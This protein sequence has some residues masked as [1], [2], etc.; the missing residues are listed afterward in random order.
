MTDGTDGAPMNSDALTRGRPD[1]RPA[2]YGVG[3][4][5]RSAE[6]ET[7]AGRSSR[8]DARRPARPGRRP[9]PGWPSH[10]P[11]SPVRPTSPVR[12]PGPGRSG[13]PAS[14]SAAEP[15]VQRVKPPA[16]RSAPPGE[17]SA[18][19]TAQANHIRRTSFFLL[20]LGL[21]GGGLVCLLVVNTTLAA[22]SFEISR[23]QHQN[24]ARTEQVQQLQQQVAVERSAAMIEK[25]ARRLHMRPDPALLFVDLR[26]KSIQ[27]SSRATGPGSGRLQGWSSVRAGHH[28]ARKTSGKAAAA[29]R[30]GQ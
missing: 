27:G 30:P 3:I 22:N 11:K 14:T 5:A 13:R 18:R 24:T 6:N 12:P 9:R 26:T 1:T 7:H 10:P 20:L 16:D 17:T 15:Q 2:G 21:L 29:G 28:A 25:E 19:G 8:P 23:L 4:R